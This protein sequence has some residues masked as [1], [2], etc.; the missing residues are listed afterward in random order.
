[1]ARTIKFPSI[2]TKL[3][4][5]SNLS[6]NRKKLC[7][8]ID[9]ST[10]VLSQ[11]ENQKARP[12]FE[13]LVKL[14][15]YLDVSL[16]YLVFGDQETASQPIDIGPW[17]SYFDNSL[18][19]LHAKTAARMAATA[20]IARALAERIEAVAEEVIQKS[21]ATGGLMHDDETMLVEQHSVSTRLLAVR[22]DYNISKTQ[23][24]TGKN[25]GQID[26][27]GRFLK[28]VA[29]NLIQGREYVFILPNK[30]RQ[31][32]DL[33]AGYRRLLKHLRVPD[34]AIRERCKFYH[35]STPVLSGCGLY[36]LDIQSIQDD[37]KTKILYE[38]LR[39]SI[40]TDGWLGYV[41]PPSE[42]LQADALMDEFHLR[43]ARESFDQILDDK[44][45]TKRM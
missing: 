14:A 21:G 37:P 2:L 29:N 39:A 23:E 4:H 34:Q 25:T 26:A 33:V 22:L 27:A 31:W 38:R 8:K 3:I 16:D 11:Y 6:G 7:S 44:K 24:G 42:Q 1:M 43:L 17:A 41:M 15:D 18:T 28:I 12:R 5:E 40:S 20:G 30:A 9:I 10:A 45:A 19:A 36:H 13:V 35:T 32:S